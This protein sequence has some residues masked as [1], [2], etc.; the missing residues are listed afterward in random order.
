MSVRSAVGRRGP[1]KAVRRVGAAVREL[2]SARKHGGS[3]SGPRLRRL[4]AALGVLATL[5]LGAYMLWLR[6]SGL[7]A[8]DEVEITGVSALSGRDAGRL[9][10]VLEGTA[11]HMTTLHVDHARLQRVAEAFPIV[12]TLD[13]RSDFPS[14]L[15]IHVFEHRPAAALV[16]GSRRVAVAADGSILASV[17]AEALPEVDGG[18]VLPADRLAP[19][20]ALDAVRIAGGAPR[21]LIARLDEVR[22]D[23]ARGLVVRLDDGPELVFGEV[24]RLAA[25]WAAAA[26]VLADARAEGAE[27]VDLRIPER[28]AAGGLLV[29]TVAPL[30]P[31]G[32]ST[33]AVPPTPGE[34]AA[35]EAPLAPVPTGSPESAE[36]PAQDSPSS[37]SGE[38]ALADP[39][40]A[41]G[42]DEE[43]GGAEGGALAGPQP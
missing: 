19:S 43:A 21:A 22:Q 20:P 38:P 33:P 31:A 2:G 9:R 35:P 1:A 5:V 7:V 12:R 36:S 37:P 25:K 13:V 27:Y 11:R 23:G 32:E 40:T 29:E 15:R 24:T 4:L 14:G 6:D 42:P 34:A 39:G 28:P 26:R 17:S 8:V 18:D 41:A 30:A 3:R 16:A 10:S